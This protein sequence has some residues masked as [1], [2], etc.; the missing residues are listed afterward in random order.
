MDT[1]FG[2]FARKTDLYTS[3]NVGEKPEELILK[4]CR[5]WEKVAVDKHKKEKAERDEVNNFH[6]PFSQNDIFC[7]TRLIVFDVKNY[8]V[9]VKK[10]KLQKMNHVL[11]KLQMKKQK[12]L[13]KKMLKLKYES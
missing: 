6:L 3:P 2:F 8:V 4:T 7:S 5:K 13:R 1:L 11:W 9:N 12:R 10:K